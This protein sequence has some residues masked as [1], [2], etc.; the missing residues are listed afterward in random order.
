M[1]RAVFSAT[2]RVEDHHWWF[3]A[4]RRIIAGQL[5]KLR[6]PRDAQLLEA[7]CGSGG[8]LSMLSG[9][10]SVYGF[11]PDA[12][13]RR[14]AQ[15]RHV[16]TVE[17]GSLPGGIPFGERRFDLIVMLDVLEHLEDDLTG[18]RALVPR[19]T[20]GGYF[21]A[22]VPAIKALWSPHDA[23]HHHFR[24]YSRKELETLLRSSGLNVISVSHFNT[25][26][27][28]LFVAERLW[29]KAVRPAR[30]PGLVIPGP[31][32]N[33]ALET[34]FASETHA[35]RRWSLPIGASLIAVARAA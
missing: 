35:L 2:A 12:E 32:L 18:L 34:T 26:L 27:F 19:M 4:R 5:G 23:S 24:R 3:R 13:Q 28:P 22:T 11:E 16:G 7:G 17:E 30:S 15:E 9:F 20:R 21:L 29:T 33:S 8:N 6:L 1:D 10:G 14:L 31:L 25:V